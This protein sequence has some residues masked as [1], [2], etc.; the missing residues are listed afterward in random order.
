[1]NVNFGAKQQKSPSE[2]LEMLKAVYCV[3]L[4]QRSHK[5][6]VQDQ[7]H[8]CFSTS[9]VSFTLNCAQ[10]T[11]VNQTFHE[12]LLYSPNLAPA[13]F[14]LFQKLRSVLRGKHSSDN[15]D[16]KSSAEKKS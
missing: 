2:I 11:T 15:E 8:I 1:M 6:Q 5:Y 4:G 3:S 14:W 12:V 9:G 7:N 13:D 10:R 16:I